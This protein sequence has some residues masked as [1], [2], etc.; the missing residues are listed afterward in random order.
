MKK[1]RPENSRWRFPLFF[2]VFVQF[3][4]EKASF[5][6][7]FSCLGVRR[8]VR[9]RKQKRKREV[10]ARLLRKAAENE[11]LKTGCTEKSIATL[12]F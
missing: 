2:V 8:L 3:Y 9:H 11:P 5:F 12:N 6:Q 4:S 1:D 7:L 10:N